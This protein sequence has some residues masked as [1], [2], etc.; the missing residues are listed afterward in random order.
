MWRAPIFVRLVFR[1]P[2][3]TVIRAGAFALGVTLIGTIKTF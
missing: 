3:T 2:I 1:S